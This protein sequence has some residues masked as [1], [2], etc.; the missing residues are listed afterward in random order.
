MENKQD[1][2]TTNNTGL[3]RDGINNA[4]VNWILCSGQLQQNTLAKGM[5]SATSSGTLAINTGK[6]TGRFLEARFIALEIASV[7][8][9][10]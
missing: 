10:Y 7:F 6:C 3:S 4:Q 8:V 5:G 9:K 2:M 1:N